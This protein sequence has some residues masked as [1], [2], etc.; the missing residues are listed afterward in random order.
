[1]NVTR[2]AGRRD[3]D[4]R[5]GRASAKLVNSVGVHA[6]DRRI[7]IHANLGSPFKGM[8]PVSP[9]EVLLELI[10][11]AVRTEDRARGLVIWLVKAIG[12]RNA[13]LDVI[14]RW[15]ER[16]AAD[17]TY[18]SIRDHVRRN[19]SRVMHSEVALMIEE[20]NAKIR[21]DRGL[22]WV[23]ERTFYLIQAEARH[24]RRLAR[25]LVINSY[26]NLIRAGVDLRRC[27][28]STIAESS[29]RLIGHRIPIQHALYLRI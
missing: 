6:E 21:V 2:P 11:I 28:V 19:G 17:V 15:E 7:P 29:G 23:C 14:G 27:G 16:S 10:E 24:Q 22:I 13:R 18:R 12:V 25:N 5:I 26:R 20:L 1:M 8:R 3:V 9:R 4:W